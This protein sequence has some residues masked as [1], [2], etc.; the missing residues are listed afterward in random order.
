M[1]RKPLQIIFIGFAVITI[2]VLSNVALAEQCGGRTTG[3]D[4]DAKKNYPPVLDPI[5]HHYI[6]DGQT[7]MFQITATDANNDLLTFSVVNLPSTAQF[8]QL[9]RLFTWTPS[10]EEGGIYSLT[11]NVSDGK[12]TDS[13]TI[14]IFVDMAAPI[15]LTYPLPFKETTQARINL[16]GMIKDDT[17]IER[18]EFKIIYENKEP[19]VGR[20]SCD[21]HYWEVA[22][23]FLTKGLNIITITAWDFFGKEDQRKFEITRQLFDETD[24]HTGHSELTSANVSRC[25]FSS[26][27]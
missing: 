13:E 27:E 21:G 25:C 16:A 24:I 17:G 18:I 20:I 5:G 4:K 10:D 15:L 22:D 19:I 14:H 7:I 26:N 23:L 2:L 9:S 11:F 12:L 8:D 1:T 3:M 6:S